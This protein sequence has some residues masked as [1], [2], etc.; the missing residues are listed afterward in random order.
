MRNLEGKEKKMDELEVVD[1][2]KP[3]IQALT[4]SKL[5]L[6]SVG[7]PQVPLNGNFALRS[8]MS[9]TLL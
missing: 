8:T 6:T 1:T 9:V 7:E 3:A 5:K 4:I 2:D